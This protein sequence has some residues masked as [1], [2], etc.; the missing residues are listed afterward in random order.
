MYTPTQLTL[1]PTTYLVNP[2]LH[3]ALVTTAKTTTTVTAGLLAGV[4]WFIYWTVALTAL[5][6]CLAGSILHANHLRAGYSPVLFTPPKG[7]MG[8]LPSAEMVHAYQEPCGP[9]PCLPAPTAPTA[10]TVTIAPTVAP[11]RFDGAG[12]QVAPTSQT[13]G[14]RTNESR[15]SEVSVL[16]LKRAAKSQGVKGYSRMRKPEL[17]T[18]LEALGVTW[19]QVHM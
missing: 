9:M 8:L 13:I 16:V 7:V 2:L 15:L 5:G 12:H 1:L 3:R 14:L 6:L 4:T 18:S 10:P 19:E 17:V 11:V